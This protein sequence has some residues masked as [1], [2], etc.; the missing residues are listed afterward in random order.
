MEKQYKSSIT[1]NHEIKEKYFFGWC[2]LKR[3]RSLLSYF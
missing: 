2:S 1:K 3:L